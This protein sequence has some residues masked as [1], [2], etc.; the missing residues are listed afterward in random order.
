MPARAPARLSP[1]RNRISAANA[2]PSAEGE[3]TARDDHSGT[4]TTPARQL[5][6]SPGR[7]RT[8]PCPGPRPARS[9]RLAGIG[10]RP[11]RRAAGRSTAAAAAPAPPRGTPSSA[12]SL[13]RTAVSTS[14]PPRATRGERRR[15]GCGRK[16]ACG[17][18]RCCPARRPR[19]SR[20]RGLRTQKPR[21]P[22]RGPAPRGRPPTLNGRG[23][24]RTGGV[25]RG[26]RRPPRPGPGGRAGR[27]GPRAPAP[28]A[29]PGGTAAGRGPAARH[30]GRRT[31]GHRAG[32]PDLRLHGEPQR[33]ADIERRPRPLGAGH[34]PA[35]RRSRPVVAR[36]VAG[37][38]RGRVRA[39]PMPGR[40][41]GAGGHRRGALRPDG[42]RR[43]GGPPG[44][45]Q[46]PV[47]RP[48]PHPARPT[49]RRGHPLDTFDAILLG[50]GPIPDG[51]VARA[52]GRAPG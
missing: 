40:R 1:K 19:R 52:A 15:R 9:T 33:G 6:R 22:H 23:G 18:G 51:L 17:Q 26:S 45:R 10:C 31:R 13:L 12:L 21:G 20:Q 36:H 34:P 14:L 16:S 41:R 5:R 4:R 46:P 7:S 42:V 29:R 28:A 39:D 35:P 3:P 24:P 32:D 47:H 49:A 27:L 30:L 44:A 48:G 43:R 25:D 37:A 11:D 50:G 38:D 2:R 8:Q